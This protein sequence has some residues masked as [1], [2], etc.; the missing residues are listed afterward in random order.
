MTTKKNVSEG[1]DR[2]D[3]LQLSKKI[4]QKNNKTI[5]IERL[6][7]RCFVISIVITIQKGLIGKFYMYFPHY[8]TKFA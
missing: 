6:K 5:Y 8:T 1:L 2:V 4:K 7:K 3:F